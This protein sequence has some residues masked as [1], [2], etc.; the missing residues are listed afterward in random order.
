MTNCK[1]N[2]SRQLVSIIIVIFGIISIS[3]GL[4][5]PKVLLPIYENNIYNFLKQPLDFINSNVNNTKFTSDI[6]YLYITKDKVIINSRNINNII[7]LNPEKILKKIIDVQ[8]KFKYLGK[9]YYYYTDKDAYVTKIALT[10]DN[11][12]NK[13]KSDIFRNIFPVLL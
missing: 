7:K 2:L 3:F 4:L 13:I 9:T 1:H 8:G 12:I 11:Y 5:F 10:N 6:A